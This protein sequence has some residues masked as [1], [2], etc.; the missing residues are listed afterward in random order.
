MPKLTRAQGLL[1][2]GLCVALISCT[3]ENIASDLNTD[4]PPRVISVTVLSQAARGEAATYCA[5]EDSGEKLNRQICPE[6]A[7][8][9]Q[10]TDARPVGWYT[11]VVFN[12]LLIAELVETLV[13]ENDDGAYDYGTL[14]ETQPVVLTCGGE[15]VAYD[16]YYVPNGS[17]LTNPPGPSLVVQPT[18]FVAS[19]TQDCEI[20]VKPDLMDKDFE[21]ITEAGPY[22][23]GIAPLS[24]VETL[25]ADCSTGVEDDRIL[26]VTNVYQYLDPESLDGTIE[27]V[28]VA[29]DGTET[30]VPVTLELYIPDPDNDEEAGDPISVKVTPTEGLAADTEYIVRVH[31]GMRDVAGGALELE[32]PYEVTISTGEEITSD[33]ECTSDDE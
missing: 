30:D 19:S 1:A 27:L 4:G 20:T 17:H 26:V 5:S 28:A 18:E 16:G 24:I 23:F 15:E 21:N 22:S 9:T 25:P 2:A 14:A 7:E 8:T 6:D 13:D 29:G 33:E 10:V 3:D 31:S 32:E 12:E 11:R